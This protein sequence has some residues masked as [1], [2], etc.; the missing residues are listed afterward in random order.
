MTQL[1][2]TLPAQGCPFELAGS[3]HAEVG[4][5]ATV[6]ASEDELAGEEASPE[7][8]D[9]GSIDDEDGAFG[10]IGAAAATIEVTEPVFPGL[11]GGASGSWPGTGSV[12]TIVLNT[13]R[14]P[15]KTSQYRSYGSL[16][17]WPVL[18]G[19]E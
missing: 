2:A 8:L 3:G 18:A 11:Q 19:I 6:A 9:W 12:F 5:A 14:K 17:Y 16:R 1:G 7:Q 4:S 13:G 15:L 10:Q